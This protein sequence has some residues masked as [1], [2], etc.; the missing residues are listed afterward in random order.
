M[1]TFDTTVFNLHKNIHIHILRITQYTFTCCLSGCD[2]HTHTHTHTHSHLLS[3]R[4]W[5]THR[6]THTHT[7][8]VSQAVTH[9][10][11]HTRTHTQTHTQSLRL[12]HTRI[13]QQ[14]LLSVP[15][16]IVSLFVLFPGCKVIYEVGEFVE[17]EVS[18]GSV[19]MTVKEKVRLCLN[20]THSLLSGVFLCS[21]RIIV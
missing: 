11:M 20:H 8:A 5:H 16:L 18:Y 7:P 2:A 21:F 19:F 12:W 14:V 13:S 17:V 15:L 1:W 9:A 3:L 10:R 6:H 4:L